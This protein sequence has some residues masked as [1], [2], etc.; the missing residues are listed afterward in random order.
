MIVQASSH[1]A[2]TDI[3]RDQR[4]ICRQKYRSRRSGRLRAIRRSRSGSTMGSPIRMLS[5]RRSKTT[6]TATPPSVCGRPDSASTHRSRSAIPTSGASA[7]RWSSADN[8]A[9]RSGVSSL[10]A[11]ASRTSASTGRDEYTD[12][13]ST[14]TRRRPASS[15]NA[16]TF[17]GVRR[18]RASA[19]D[20]QRAGRDSRSRIDRSIAAELQGSDDS[21]A[22]E[23][24]DRRDSWIPIQPSGRA[25]TLAQ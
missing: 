7:R 13:D 4:T 8:A 22:G 23:V 18:S 14:S 11:S 10:R 21:S 19:S 5:R 3:R 2:D 1:A 20:D 9:S 16:S 15:A 17:P 24:D 6:S 12:A 25:R